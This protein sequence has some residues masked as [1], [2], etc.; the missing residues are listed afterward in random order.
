MNEPDSEATD[1]ASRRQQQFAKV[2]VKIDAQY[3]TESNNT[4]LETEQ[5]KHRTR[6][7]KGIR[8]M[9]QCCR[10]HKKSSFEEAH[11]NV[12]ST[13]C[14]FKQLTGKQYVNQ[15]LAPKTATVSN[16]AKL[17]EWPALFV[18]VVIL[19]AGA[20]G[21]VLGTQDLGVW[22]AVTVALSSGVQAWANACRLDQ[23]R[24]ASVSASQKLGGILM[25]WKALPE[26]DTAKQQYIDD[27]VERTESTLASLLPPPP[28]VQAQAAM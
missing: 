8:E 24:N 21:S 6:W 10:V 19:A 11:T 16:E 4:A 23:R 14:R 18:Q 22:I 25:W 1:L 27:L 7:W 15:R 5:G 20:V 2:L 13:H 17:L 12:T 26:E 9:V 3:S 28:H